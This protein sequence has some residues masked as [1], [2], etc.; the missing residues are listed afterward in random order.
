MPARSARPNCW[1]RRRGR[2]F[3]TPVRRPAA[4]PRICS[5]RPISICWR[6]ISTPAG[7]RRIE[8]N[9]QRLGLSADGQGRRLQRGRATGGMAGRSTPFSPMCPARLPAWCVVIRT[10]STCAAKAISGASCTRQAAI[11]DALWPLLKPGGKLL[12]ATCSVF[13]GRKLR[14]RSTPFSF[15]S[16]APRACLKSN[17]CRRTITT[18]FIMRCCKKLLRSLFCGVLL[19]LAAHAAQATDISVRSPQLVANEDGYSLAADFNIN[20]NSRLEEA[21]NKGVVLYFAVDFEL[22]RSRWYWFDEQVIRRSKTFQLSY[23]ALTRQYRLSTG[24]LHQSYATLDEALRVMSHLRN[25]QVLEKGEIKAD[26][27]YLAGLRM[28]LDLT[29]MPKTFQVS[30]LSNKDW[31]LSSDWLRW[32]FTPSE[33]SQLADAA[34][35]VPARADYAPVPGATTDRCQVRPNERTSSS[36]PPRS[37]ASCSFCSPRPA[38]IRRCS[39]AIIR[40]CSGSTRLSPCRSSP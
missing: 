16:P 1:R 22:T 21:V 12:Y 6:S 32:S 40:G 39:P 14:R 19:L 31:N 25:W 17:C 24:A 11:L 33:R 27:T 29:Q 9:L 13:P 26:Q 10:S 5:N 35:A 37:A 34:A 18:V 38:P 28:R 23:H 7:R 36:S 4:R 3:S 20:F 8:E 30:A 15:A 2:A